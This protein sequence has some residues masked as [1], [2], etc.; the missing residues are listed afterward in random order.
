MRKTYLLFDLFESHLKN[1]VGVDDDHIVEVALDDEESA[2][3]RDPSALNDFLRSRIADKKSSY[4]VLLDEVQYAISDEE[5]KGNEPPRLYGVLNGLLRMRNVDVYV[6]DSNSRLLSSD[7]MAQ[8]RGRG[9]EVRVRPLSFSEFMQGFEGD[10]YEGWAEYVAYGGMP[11]TLFMRTDEQKARYLERLFAETYLKDVVVRNKIIKT[12]EL[13]DLVDVLASL[14]GALTNPPKIEA[15]FKSVLKSKISANTISSYI[16]YLEESFLIEEARRYDVKGRKYIG[17]P[18]KYHFEDI[19]LRNARLN[20]RQIEETH[21]M[22]NIVYNELRLRGFSVDVGSVEKAER[23]GGR[24]VRKQLEVDF[25]A[26]M[27][28]NRY[29]IQSALHLPDAIKERQEKASLNEVPDSFKKIVLVRDVV[30]PVYDKQGIL[31]MSVY[32]FLLN[33]DS[34]R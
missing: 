16:R 23:N 18:K 14:I 33:Q 34:L 12:Q 17:S 8:F 11:L 5:L 3:L 15:T 6:T 27:G 7:V 9:D 10:K 19:G 2:R 29:Y 25:V 26:N 28:S 4:Y 20:F 22:E 30:K 21:I 1:E 13:E 31:T 32:D 24:V